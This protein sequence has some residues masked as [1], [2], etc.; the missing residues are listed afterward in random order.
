[1]ALTVKID[2]V[3]YQTEKGSISVDL[4]IGER[5]IASCTVVDIDDAYTF[6][7]NQPVL[8]YDSNDDLIFGGAIENPKEKQM[9]PGG[10]SLHPLTMKDYHYLCDKRLVAESY[11]DK[12]CGFIVDDIYDNYLAAEGVTIGSIEL[13]ATLLESIFNYV[14]VDQCFSAL[15]EKAGMVWYIDENKALYFQVRTAVAAP[16]SATR[17]NTKGAESSGMNPLYRN[18]QYIRGGRG[19]TAA[20]TETFIA[21]GEQTAFTVSYPLQKVPTSIKVDGGAALTMGIKGLDSPGD[22]ESYW[23]KGDATITLTTAPAAT[24]EV[25]IIYY[26][27][28]DILTLAEDT[29][30]IAAQVVIEGGGTGYVD[31]VGDEPTLDDADASLDSAQAK[32]DKFA[33]SRLALSY[34]TVETGLFPGQLQTSTFTNLGIT[35]ESLL[36]ESVRIVGRG[37]DV[38][39]YVTSSRGP[40][41]GSWAQYFQDLANIRTEMN[42]RLNVGSEQILIILVTRKETWEV[43]ESVAYTIY[44]CDLI[45]TGRVDTAIVC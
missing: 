20:Q 31:A 13:G 2:G 28:F 9:A 39:Y 32:L 27:Q 45:D 15:A 19:T 43:T 42:D 10:G 6:T 40:T 25:V 34:N 35:A 29:D 41:I 11:E 21:D 23:S 38:V 22:Y 4:R 1:M 26:G 36:I 8:I 30:E 17:A 16:W 12:T 37:E 7:Q 44:T 3:F 5:S 33:T 18:R 14:T 24:K